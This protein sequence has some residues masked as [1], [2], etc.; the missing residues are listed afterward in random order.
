[1]GMANAGS[2]ALLSAGYASHGVYTSPV[3][4]ATQISRFGKI[5]LHG[6]ASAS[7]PLLTVSTRSGNLKEPTEK[8]W[9]T[10]TDEVPAAEYQPGHLRPLLASC[11]TSI[12]VHT[13][14]RG[15]DAFGGGCRG[16]VSDAE[17][18]AGGAIGETS[19]PACINLPDSKRPAAD[20]AAT[21]APA[22]TISAA[23]R[24]RRDS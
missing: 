17:P 13:E 4:D 9:S 8:G 7:A 22:R 5:R 24:Q 19:A 1:M 6:C 11:N 12:D 2:I 14:Q 3:L 18:P 20:D 16:S 10:W 23:C 15:S 21:A